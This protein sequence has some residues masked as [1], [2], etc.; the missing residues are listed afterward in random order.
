MRGLFDCRRRRAACAACLTFVD[1]AAFAAFLTFVDRAAFAAFFTP[2]SK[3]RASLT[4]RN[5]A[6]D[7]PA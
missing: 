3:A 4:L 7:P 2:A 1:K 6:P 5:T